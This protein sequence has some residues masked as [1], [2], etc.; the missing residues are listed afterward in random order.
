M[1]V[2]DYLIYHLRPYGIVAIPQ[3]VPV[4]VTLDEL[5]A[6]KRREDAM[7]A[8]KLKLEKSKITQTAKVISS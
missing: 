2:L 4:K 1:Y 5:R 6:E 7:K 8:K 3:K